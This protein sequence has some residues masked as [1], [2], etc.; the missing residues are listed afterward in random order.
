MD[1]A[2]KDPRSTGEMTTALGER[3]EELRDTAAGVADEVRFGAAIRPGAA[4]GVAAALVALLVLVLR[5]RRR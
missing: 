1:M 5:W 4:A 3:A 2:A